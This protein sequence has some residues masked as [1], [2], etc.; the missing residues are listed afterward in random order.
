M[1]FYPKIAE[2]H[3]KDRNIDIKIPIRVKLLGLPI[4]KCQNEECKLKIH[5]E[6]GTLKDYIYYI[7]RKHYNMPLDKEKLGIE[8][9]TIKNKN[10]PKE[11][12]NEKNEIVCPECK[13]VMVL[14]TKELIKTY[15]P[16]KNYYI[17]IERMLNQFT[18][19]KWRPHVIRHVGINIEAYRISLEEVYER[20]EYLNHNPDKRAKITIFKN[21]KIEQLR[22]A[23][24]EYQARKTRLKIVRKLTNTQ[25]YDE[26]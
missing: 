5:N 1:T 4:Y 26:E 11:L 10:I 16:R 8:Y 12:L 13:K 18:L 9:T 17:D 24:T 2:L 14:G 25:R 21:I 3:Y 22:Q 15:T 6:E 23:E 20:L 19:L 7:E